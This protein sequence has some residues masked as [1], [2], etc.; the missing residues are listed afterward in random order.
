MSHKFENFNSEEFKL[1]KEVFETIPYMDVNIAHIVE[2]YIYSMKRE[3]Y[4]DG[5]LQYEYRK[6][7]DVFDGVFRQ[8]EYNETLVLECY[9]KDGKEHGEYKR[10]NPRGEMTKKCYYNEGKL[11]GEY[12][13]WYDNKIYSQENYKDGKLEGECKVWHDNG[14]LK[15]LYKC[16][17]GKRE[18]ELLSWNN[19]G[20]L[21]Y[22][23]NYKQGMKI[24]IDF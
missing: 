17:N 9:F 4:D 7:G 24:L 19:K 16:E 10:C 12:T 5:E 21:V 15:N 6:K 14:Q 22:K 13:V 8:W 20:E 11:E 18:G 1:V 3:Y 23:S 2:E